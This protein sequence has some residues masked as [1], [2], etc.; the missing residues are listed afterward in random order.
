MRPLSDLGGVGQMSFKGVA[1]PT[2]QSRR[3][4]RC[5]VIR[6]R[7]DFYKGRPDCKRCHNERQ[8]VLRSDPRRRAENVRRV[9][10]WR[11]AHPERY[12]EYQRA[13]KE[14][15]REQIQ[16]AN[17]ERHLKK[18]YGISLT[19]YEALVECQR[20]VCAICRAP[21]AGGLHIDHDHASGRVRGLLC[22]RC[23]KALGLLDDD[24][25]RFRAAAMYLLGS[26]TD[27]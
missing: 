16:R 26:P 6:P 12:L 10:A 4:T 14:E 9:Q 20:G 5:G 3:C 17:R 1:H 8:R 11:K 24:P 13:Y 7:S 25:K 19:E 27:N 2:A 23:N 22:G 18:Q 15:N 21:E